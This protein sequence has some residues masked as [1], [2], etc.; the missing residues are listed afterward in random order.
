MLPSRVP[1]ARTTEASPPPGRVRDRQV[2]WEG[3]LGDEE[4]PRDKDTGRQ[5][6]VERYTGRQKDR[7][8]KGG[9]QVFP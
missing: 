9:N 8:T 1:A 5:K 2:D 6:Q 4:K 7:E 3:G